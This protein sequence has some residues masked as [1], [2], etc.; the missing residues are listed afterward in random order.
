M[1]GRTLLLAGLLAAAL[2]TPAPAQGIFGKKK[3]TNKPTPAE[4]VA[5]LLVTLKTDQDLSKRESAASELRQFEPK[6]FPEI[7]PALIETLQT[8]PKPEVRREAAES[9]GRLSP[10]SQQ[11]GWALEQAASKDSSWRVKSQAR[12]SLTWY[13]IKGYRSNGKP[14]EDLPPELELAKP[15]QTAPPLPPPVAPVPKVP[16][17][18]GLLPSETAPPPLAM[19]PSLLPRP[20][21][22]GPK[23]DG[24]AKNPAPDR[25]PDLPLP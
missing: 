16:A 3:P 23:L 10:V 21:P 11:A 24:P 12:L 14:T 19:P 18:P 25:G 17:R 6:T 20:L 15:G 8:D 4:R 9:L 13:R 5:E 7:I 1:T 22:E 2:A